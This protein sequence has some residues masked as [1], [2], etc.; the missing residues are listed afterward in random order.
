[1]PRLRETT[2]DAIAI[3]LRALLT[4]PRKPA[5]VQLVR[6]DEPHR[7]IKEVHPLFAL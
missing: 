6:I 1:M 5:P 4:S 3:E 7:V 2:L